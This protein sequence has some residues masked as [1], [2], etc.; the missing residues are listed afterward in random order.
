MGLAYGHSGRIPNY[1][2]TGIWSTKCRLFHIKIWDVR[3]LFVDNH[4]FFVIGGPATSLLFFLRV[5]AVYNRSRI[6]T[7]FFG[8]LWLG[9]TGT[10]I[11]ITIGTT[12]SHIP[13]T[14]RC[15]EGLAPIY[16]TVPIILTAVNDTLVFL[17]ISYRM[18]FSAMVRST[19]RARARS[20]FMGEG[21][22]QLSKAL[23]QSGQVYYF[24]TIGVAITWTALILSPSIPG[25]L[26][27]ILGSAYFALANAMACRVF[28][29]VL[30]ESIKDPQTNPTKLG[31]FHRPNADTRDVKPSRSS[32]LDIN[33]VVKTA[34]AAESNDWYPLSETKLTGDGM[35]PEDAFHSV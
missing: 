11:L 26:H 18:V 29:A 3:L 9:I 20:F 5:R 27:P 35:Q 32:K 6:I 8:I 19:W 30:L 28:R 24:V 21:L 12:D 15:I 31:S 10:S 25:Q 17:A 34:T 2:Q 16:T 4:I 22:H 23:L 7:A 14:R 1:L 13:Y 33:V